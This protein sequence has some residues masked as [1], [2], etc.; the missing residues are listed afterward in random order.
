MSLETSKKLGD[1]PRKLYRKAKQES[2]RGADA[3]Y[4][5]LRR[6]VRIPD[7]GHTPIASAALG[8]ACVGRS[9]KPVGEPDAGKPHVRFDEQ[10]RETEL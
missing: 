1:L 2:P 9:M 8:T 3:R 5:A 4:P 10:G 6:Q 7:T